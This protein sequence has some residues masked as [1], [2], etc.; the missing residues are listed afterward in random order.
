VLEAGT[1]SSALRGH[2]LEIHKLAT[3]GMLN[4][5]SPGLV[6][7]GRHQPQPGAAQGGPVAQEGGDGRQALVL[8]RL[9]WHGEPGVA[10]EQREDGVDVAGFDG[11]GEAAREVALAEGAGHRGVVAAGGSRACRAARARCRAPLTEASVLSSMPAASA[12]G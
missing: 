5:T 9:G 6:G 4:I 8:V 1:R 3:R 11:G 10:G 12:A 7:P 2:A